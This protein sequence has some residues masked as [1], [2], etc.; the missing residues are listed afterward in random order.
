MII[1]INK[2]IYSI[3]NAIK[4]EFGTDYAIYDE[5]VKQGVEK[6][7]FFI[8]P[9]KLSQKYGFSGRILL[10]NPFL[11]QYFP[12]I[13]SRNKD[14]NEVLKRMFSAL[15]IINIDFHKVRG[16]NI[17]CEINGRSLDSELK[18]QNESMDGV[19]NFY[20]NYDFHVIE[21][22]E[23]EVMDKLFITHNLSDLLTQQKGE[24]K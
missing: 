7:C 4:N 1:I 5:E 10:I 22:Q 13:N 17:Y 14:L 18:N 8:K 11:I 24:F 3:A 2:V 6:P 23:H 16:S 19:M 15:S 20:I 21:K 9:L 12:D